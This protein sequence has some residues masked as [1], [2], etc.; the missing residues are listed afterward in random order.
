MGTFERDTTE[1]IE[2]DIV[3]YRGEV[4]L[5]LTTRTSQQNHFAIF[6]HEGQH[7]RYH[8]W[9]AGGFNKGRDPPSL[10]QTPQHSRSYGSLHEQGAKC[11]TFRRSGKSPFAEI[12]P[13]HK[14]TLKFRQL[15]CQITYQT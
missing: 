1:W 3:K 4:G 14:C 15:H 12:D 2:M 13:D 7:V 10:R 5:I 8:R 6:T 11:P 9:N